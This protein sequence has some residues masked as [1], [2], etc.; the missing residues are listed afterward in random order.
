MN[1]DGNTWWRRQQRIETIS[2]YDENCD[3]DK[4]HNDDEIGCNNGGNGDFGGTM[5]VAEEM[6]G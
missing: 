1:D 6:T 4:M 3:G 2:S 5:K